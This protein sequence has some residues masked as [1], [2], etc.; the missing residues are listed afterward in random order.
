MENVETC[1]L[2]NDHK[3]YFRD[4]YGKTTPLLYLY[5]KY[6]EFMVSHSSFKPYCKQHDIQSVN[7]GSH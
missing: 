7:Y 3:S 6:D 1:I 5:C 4:V 2:S